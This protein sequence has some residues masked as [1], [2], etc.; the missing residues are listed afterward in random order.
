V[1][2]TVVVVG[3]NLAGGTAAAVLRDQGFDG[4]L[5]LIGA[6]DLPP[7]ERPPLSKEFLRGEQDLE[8]GFVRP[9][10]WWEEHDIEMRLGTRVERLDGAAREVVLDGGERIGFDRAV[11]ATGARP[12]LLRVPGADL[13]GVWELRRA[14]DAEQI[15]TAAGAGGRAVLVGMGF[16]GAEVAASLR[17][18]G[19]D[20]TVIEVFETSLYRVLGTDLGR[21]IEAMH[22]DHGVE[23]IFNDTLERVEGTGRAERVVTSRGRSIESSFVVV[24]IGTDPEVGIMGGANLAVDGGLEVD[25][26]LQ[27]AIPGVYAA[28]DVASH[29]HRVFGR[30][31]VEHYD[32]AL[33]M[34]EAAAHNVLGRD[35]VF[36]DPHWFWSDQYD[37][38]I[39]MSGYA[40]TWERMVVRGS[41]AD[42]RYCAFLLQDGRLRSAVSMDWPRDA[43]RTFELI[44]SQVPVDERMLA[45]PEVDPRTLVPARRGA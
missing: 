21:T 39:Q 36:D 25:A 18:L 3:A 33:K 9:P 42:R 28:G 37:T 10:G 20:V 19:M 5:V 2:G 6:E 22:R 1:P 16:V 35:E 14:A 8:A 11:V 45:D 7:Y 43:R 31:R 40:P 34:G 24:G 26:R 4:R 38:N 17:R 23:M 27:T 41:L 30:I 44:R 29:D 15:R 12:R 32:N 13:E